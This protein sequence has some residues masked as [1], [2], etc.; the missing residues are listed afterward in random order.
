MTEAVEY[1]KS[2]LVFRM[3]IPS[4]SSETKSK[5]SN[6]QEELLNPVHAS[7]P[8]SLNSA[9]MVSSHLRL[10]LPSGLFPWGFIET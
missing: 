8:I 4:P 2:T 9:L 6:Q 10:D 5:P 3:N 1:S 7:H